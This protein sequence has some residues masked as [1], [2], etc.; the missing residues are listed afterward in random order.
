MSER[1]TC[2]F[3]IIGFLIAMSVLGYLSTR[4]ISLAKNHL[5]YVEVQK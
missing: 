4:Q 1:N 3:A 5:H 2:T